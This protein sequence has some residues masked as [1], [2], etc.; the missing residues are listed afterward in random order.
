MERMLSKLQSIHHNEPITAENHYDFLY[1]LQSALLLAMRERERLNPME[2]RYADEKLKEQRRNR[3][4][5]ILNS[6]TCR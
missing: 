2:Y 6:E 4:R 3:A 1:L 5:N